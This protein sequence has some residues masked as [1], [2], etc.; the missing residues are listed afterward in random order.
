MDD[1][2][3]RLEFCDVKTTNVYLQLNVMKGVNF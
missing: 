2:T 1:Y 3:N